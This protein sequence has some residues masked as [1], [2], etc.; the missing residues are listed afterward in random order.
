MQSAYSTAPADRA[1]DLGEIK[2]ALYKA[3]GTDPFIIWKQLVGQRLK[4]SETVD[5]Y[6]TDLRGQAVSFGRATDHIL[7]CAFMAGLINDV[8]QLL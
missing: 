5:I 8:S 4:P 6:L 3:F 2:H 1:G 7:E